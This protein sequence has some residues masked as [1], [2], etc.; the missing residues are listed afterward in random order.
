VTPDEARALG[1]EL[2]RLVLARTRIPAHRLVCP[3]ER[4]DMT[5][6][7]AKDGGLCVVQ[8]SSGT[9]ICVGCEVSVELELERERGKQ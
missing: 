5:P 9:P 4:S 3:R 7:V 6:C 1:D 2:R 8:T